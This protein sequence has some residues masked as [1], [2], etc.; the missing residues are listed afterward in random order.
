MTKVTVMETETV[1]VMG[2]VTVVYYFNVRA[3]IVYE[4]R[5]KGN[6]RSENV[7]NAKV[8]ERG[9]SKNELITV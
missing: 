7:G 2:T 5:M 4:R 1:K 8:K 6:K 9:Q 3:E